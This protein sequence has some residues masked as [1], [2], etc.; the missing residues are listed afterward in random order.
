[1]IRHLAHSQHTDMVFAGQYAVVGE[2][3]KV[4]TVRIEQ[5]TVVFGPLITMGQCILVK[6]PTPHTSRLLMGSGRNPCCE[7]R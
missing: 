6:L 5:D 1:M 7:Y 2:V 4:V 3:D